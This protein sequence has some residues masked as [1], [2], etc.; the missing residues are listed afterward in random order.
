MFRVLFAVVLYP[1]IVV[2][3]F[4]FLLRFHRL[5]LLSNRYAVVVWLNLF[6]R[7]ARKAVLGLSVFDYLLKAPRMFAGTRVLLKEKKTAYDKKMTTHLRLLSF[8]G[9]KTVLNLILH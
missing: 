4:F 6:R 9:K 5:P 8:E 2:A 7:K 1:L 3:V